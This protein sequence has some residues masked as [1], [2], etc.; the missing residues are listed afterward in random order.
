MDVLI[1]PF[2]A[3]I[4]LLL[5]PACTTTSLPMLQQQQIWSRHSE[6]LTGL[7]QWDVRGRIALQMDE[8]AWQLS[9]RWQ[10]KPGEQQIDLAGPFGMGAVRL[11][12]NA[13]GARLRD[14]SKAEYQAATAQQLLWQTTGWILPLDNLVWW[15]RGL[16]V[17][18]KEKQMEL[19]GQG[20]LAKLVQ[21]GWQMEVLEYESSDGVQLPHL[22]ELKNLNGNTQGKNMHL[23]LVISQWQ[24]KKKS[25]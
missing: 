10:H 20:R 4:F 3:L 25:G 8:E 15:L 19:D 21:D 17:P 11:F 2:L 12:I 14:S 9:L 1:R 23:R 6:R 13:D 24:E 7:T 5:L 22:I 18:Q 16:P